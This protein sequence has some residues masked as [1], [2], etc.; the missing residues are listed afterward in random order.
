MIPPRCQAL[1]HL[2]RE[3][4]RAIGGDLQRQ[5]HIPHLARETERNQL[6]K[7]KEL[8]VNPEGISEVDAEKTAYHVR[9]QLGK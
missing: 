2:H 4:R 1:G 6:G 3:R 5:Q 8:N 9:R 7:R